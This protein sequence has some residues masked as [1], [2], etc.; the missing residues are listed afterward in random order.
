MQA[1]AEAFLCNLGTVW[2]VGRQREGPKGSPSPFSSQAA[3][4]S[5]LGLTGKE[6][7][8]LRCWDPWDPCWWKSALRGTSSQ[9]WAGL[10]LSVKH[11]MLMLRPTWEH[12][13]VPGGGLEIVG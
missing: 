3:H 11:M 2:V 8:K 10:Q 9:A 1:G 12:L 6:E 13:D 4:S 5:H 7:E